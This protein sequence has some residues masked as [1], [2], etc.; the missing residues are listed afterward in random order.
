MNAGMQLNCVPADDYGIDVDAI[1]L[2][3][4]PQKIKAW[5][6]SHLIIITLPR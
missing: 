3:M 4:P 5:H 6:T 2:T 1:E